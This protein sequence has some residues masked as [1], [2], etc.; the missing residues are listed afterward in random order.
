[1]I[2]D[3]LLNT[4]ASITGKSKDEIKSAVVQGKKILKKGTSFSDGVRILQN[5]G[6]DDVFV[7]NMNRRFG[8]YAGKFG[9]SQDTVSSVIGSI[10]GNGNQQSNNREPARKD[11]FDRNKYKKI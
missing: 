10:S 3:F 11:G 1:M 6:M 2:T 9:I 8:R 5:M 4:A 7:D